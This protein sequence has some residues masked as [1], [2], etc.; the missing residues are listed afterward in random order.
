MRPFCQGGDELR[1]DEVGGLLT[2]S[3]CGLGLVLWLIYFNI[4]FSFSGTNSKYYNF[5]LLFYLSIIH[6]E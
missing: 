3:L 6:C 1:A 2:A 5:L 4:C